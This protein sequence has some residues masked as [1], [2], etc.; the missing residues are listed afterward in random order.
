M[1]IFHISAITL[2]I[3]QTFHIY[4]TWY[5]LSNLLYNPFTSIHISFDFISDLIL[6]QSIST[7][8]SCKDESFHIYITSNS[9][10]LLDI[11]SIHNFKRRADIFLVCIIFLISSSIKKRKVFSCH[12]FFN[13]VQQ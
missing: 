9:S 3:I 12:I 6:S 11:N 5:S 13:L 8:Q 2:Q 7:N 10:F 4:I 1:I